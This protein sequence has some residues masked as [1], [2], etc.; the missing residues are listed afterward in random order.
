MKVK[1]ELANFS[2]SFKQ[3]VSTFVK[4][5]RGAATGNEMFCC[6][7]HQDEVVTGFEFINATS[8]KYKCCKM[9]RTLGQIFAPDFGL[10]NVKAWEGYYCPETLDVS[11]RPEYQLDKYVGGDAIGGRTEF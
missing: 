1:L 10:E 8:M 5:K 3:R 7:C 4:D 9:P 2:T 11:G 6:R